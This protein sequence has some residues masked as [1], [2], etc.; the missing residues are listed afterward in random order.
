[1]YIIIIII[2]IIT[3]ITTDVGALETSHRQAPHLTKVLT[4][5]FSTTQ[6]LPSAA[7]LWSLNKKQLRLTAES[8]G[9]KHAG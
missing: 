6:S 4:S 2:I 5:N 8:I 3:I 7:D 1:M 9:L